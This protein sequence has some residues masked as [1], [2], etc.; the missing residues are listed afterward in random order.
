VYVEDR[1][2]E[3]E[4]I[5]VALARMIFA[6]GLQH[7]DQGRRQTRGLGHA[8][9]R[10]AGVIAVGDLGL[11]LETLGFVQVVKLAG[12]DEYLREMNDPIH[13]TAGRRTV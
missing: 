8:T 6:A 12:H 5:R 4:A 11:S 1:F 3:D 10:V 13:V 9:Q 2:R 7:A